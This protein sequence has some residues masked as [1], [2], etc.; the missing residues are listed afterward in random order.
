PSGPVAGGACDRRRP[1]GSRSDQPLS[2]LT[3]PACACRT[4]DR[5]P[6]DAGEDRQPRRF[7]VTIRRGSL[8]IGK[9][10]PPGPAGCQGKGYMQ[11]NVLELSGVCKKFGAFT[12]VDDMSFVI[13]RG[14]VH[15]FLGP[16]GAGKTTTIRMI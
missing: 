3:A 4:M 14:S 16:N 10:L 11:K 8:L 7:A 1:S 13:P 5:H 12:A 9:L 15:G 2:G 6:A